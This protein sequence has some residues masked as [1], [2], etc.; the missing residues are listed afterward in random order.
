MDLGSLIVAAFLSLGLIGTDAVLN[1]GTVNFDIQVT[2]DL[3]KRGFTPQLV[4]AMMDIDLK[5]LVDFKSMIHPPQIRSSQQKSVV[6]AVADSLN[7]KEVTSS[8]QSDFGLNP[9]RLTGSLMQ[10]GKDGQEFRFVLAGESRHTGQFIIDETSAGRPLPKFLDDMAIEVVA[11][12]EPYAAAIHEF[13]V[14]SANLIGDKSQSGHEAF[15]DYI[16]ALAASESGEQD[17]DLDHSALH[18]L[19]GL[20]ALMA[21]DLAGADEA[22]KMSI[23]LDPTMGI[24]L[25]NLALA[26]VSQHDFDAAITLADSALSMRRVRD[27]PY[28]F[29]NAYTVKALALWGKNDLKGAAEQFRAAVWAYPAT[30]WGYFYWAE[31]L[32]SVGNKKDADLLRAR[33]QHNL[34]TYETYPEVAFLHVRVLTSKGFAL[35]PIYHRKN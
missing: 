4:E 25:V 9:V 30:M 14:M 29:A 17:S 23:A 2:D 24:P 5:A 11:K 35:K 16:T 28:V 18:N 20:S 15:K 33:A 13:S 27:T 32:N 7:L 6:G 12:I 22:F 8:F 31:L 19:L 26:D 1:A 10:S 3:S 21:H 34:N